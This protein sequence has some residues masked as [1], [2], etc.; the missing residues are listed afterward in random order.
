MGRRRIPGPGSWRRARRSSSLPA[1]PTGTWVT[2]DVRSVIFPP[3][4]L[5]LVVASSFAAFMSTVS[6][7]I[8]WGAICI[9]NDL[10]A[11]FIRPEA[12]D[13]NAAP[14]RRPCSS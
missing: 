13:R 7:R 14:G 12:S 11:R 3:E 6:T 10:H 8:D 1:W 5:G 4:R 9:V 2:Q